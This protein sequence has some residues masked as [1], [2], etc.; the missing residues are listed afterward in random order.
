MAR[1]ACWE[2]KTTHRKRPS[3]M[4]RT[5]FSMACSVRGGS[6]DIVA[7]TSVDA[8]KRAR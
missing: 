7:T 4:P 3:T 8:P 6:M 1:T 2:V 5:A